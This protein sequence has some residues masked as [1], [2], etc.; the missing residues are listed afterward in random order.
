MQSIWHSCHLYLEG[1]LMHASITLIMTFNNNIIFI[2]CFLFLWLSVMSVF[3]SHHVDPNCLL[4]S[5]LP[6]YDCADKWSDSCSIFGSH[7]RCNCFWHWIW[8][9][10]W[11]ITVVQ[12]AAHPLS[13]YGRLLSP[14]ITWPYFSKFSKNSLFQMLSLPVWVY[15]MSNNC[16]SDSM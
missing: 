3:R 12:S 11:N 7:Y 4:D 10:S 13:N 15:R 14:V 16:T 8:Q 6:L 2:H 9:L 1:L 5:G